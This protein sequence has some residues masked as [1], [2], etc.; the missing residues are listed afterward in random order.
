MKIKIEID[1]DEL[2]TLIYE[3][4][5]DSLGSIRLDPTKVIIQVKSTQNWK[6]EWESAEF[7]AIY[8]VENGH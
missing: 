2:K 3:K 1:Q 8:E 4:I 6:S 7:K 5:Q